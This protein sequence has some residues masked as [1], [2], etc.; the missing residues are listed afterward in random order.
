[1]RHCF[2]NRLLLTGILAQSRPRTLPVILI[3]PGMAAVPDP[4]VPALVRERLIQ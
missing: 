2:L 1:M 4:V 3:D